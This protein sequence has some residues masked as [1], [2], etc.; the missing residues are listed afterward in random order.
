MAAKGKKAAR[1]RSPTNLCNLD[2]GFRGNLKAFVS[3]SLFHTAQTNACGA[4]AN[5]FANAIDDGANALKVGVP[6]AAPGVVG[7]ADHVAVMR[8]F[9]ADS[10]L[11]WRD[12][13]YAPRD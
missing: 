8:R 9:A 1:S 10:T 11:Q 12:S 13:F 2:E 7:V 5:L 6:A 4:D 3:G